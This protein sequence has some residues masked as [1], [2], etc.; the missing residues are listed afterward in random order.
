M[1]IRN[2]GAIIVDTLRYDFIK[3]SFTNAGPREYLL[4]LGCG[5]KPFKPYY[6][7]IAKKSIGIDVAQSPHG[8][9]AVDI[10]YDGK[11]F[12]FKEN[13]FDLV[14]CTEVME[15]VPDPV[16]FL[17]EINRVMQMN[18]K[19]IMTT[20][21]MVPLHEEPYDF[22][23]YTKYGIKELLTRSGFEVEQITPF[24]DYFGV[25]MAFQM[26]IYLKFWNIISK[27][28]KLNV[29]YSE[30][31]PFIFFPVVIPQ[32]LYLLYLKLPL[33]KGLRRYLFRTTRGYGYT[34]VK[35]SNL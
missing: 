21:F 13:E 9:N 31:N 12:P 14:F 24:A 22:Y 10:V 30:Y 5:V 2:L 15:H 26:Q 33:P 3:K 4:D 23:R 18:G 34:A 28:T 35:K 7:T 1:A 25:I 6:D 19:L 29:I 27:M 8:T 32:W 16:L 11:I 17:S 20:P